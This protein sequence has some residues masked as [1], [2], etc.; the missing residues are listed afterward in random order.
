MITANLRLV[1]HIAKKYSTMT[2]SMDMQDL[3]QE[4]TI[5]LIRGI[6]KYDPERGYALATYCFW[7]VRQAISRSIRTKERVMRLPGH[8]AEMA[9][10]WGSRRQNLRAKLER[11]PTVAEM[12]EAFKV[13][14]QDVMLFMERGHNPI[15]LDLMVGQNDD[16]SI[17]ELVA[18]PRDAEGEEAIEQALICE[19]GS[20]VREALV[21]LD[22]KDRMAVELRYGL[23]G[24]HPMTLKE[25]GAQ[26]GVT[27]EAARLRL[28]RACNRLRILL[29]STYASRD[30]LVASL[31]A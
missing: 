1:I 8:V 6:E 24:E 20:A 7:W 30:N 18:D 5:G 12:A 26:L 16:T 27:R 4:G 29:R 17:G 2:T 22:P 31:A 15:S 11:E 25:L 28:T 13:T 14:E 3:I 23:T 21:H 19:M 10:S 9:Y